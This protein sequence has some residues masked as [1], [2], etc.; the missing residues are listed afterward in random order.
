[1]ISL[2]K[3]IRL[4]EKP[5]SE[6]PSEGQHERWVLPDSSAVPLSQRIRGVEVS[7]FGIQIRSELHHSIYY[8]ESK[9]E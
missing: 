1:M 2:S 6:F 5:K 8:E 4:I 3:E 7:D 9:S